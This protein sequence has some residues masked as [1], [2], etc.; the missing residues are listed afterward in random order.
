MEYGIET[1]RCS[2]RLAPATMW[3]EEGDLLCLCNNRSFS[4]S[5]IKPC[6]LPASVAVHASH[7]IKLD[8]ILLRLFEHI[9]DFHRR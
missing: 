3:G 1:K 5:V 4:S 6:T 8:E 9:H 2:L 7:D